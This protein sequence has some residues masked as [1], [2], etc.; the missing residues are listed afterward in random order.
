[1]GSLVDEPLD[2]QV[3]AWL[4]GRE[5][6]IADPWPLYSRMRRETAIFEIGDLMLV[7]RYADVLQLISDPR[8]SN[9]KFDNLLVKSQ[10]DQLSG[11]D[12]VL[13]EE[14]ADFHSNFLSAT[15]PP[16]HARRRRLQMH[17]FY[18]R[19]LSRVTGYVEATVDRLLDAATAK[20]DFDFVADFAY[21]LPML[22]I[23][24]MLGVPEE[25]MGIVLKGSQDHG[26]VLGHGFHKVPEVAEGLW[27]FKN[28]VEDTIE[29]RRREPKDDLLGALI[30]AHYLDGQ[31]SPIELTTSFFNL[32]FS[33]H[34][35]TT[36][37]LANGM[38]ALLQNPGQWARLVD[39]ENTIDATVEELL[40]FVSPVQSIMRTVPETFEFQD[41]VIR[42][43]VLIRLL[44]GS[45]NHDPDFFQDPDE[46]NVGRPND[47]VAHVVFGKGVHYCMGN[48][49][50]RLEMRAAFS[51]IA[52]RTPRPQLASDEI[53]W[54]SS[55]L[56]RR[57]AAL[58]MR[59]ES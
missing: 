6:L 30:N 1:M 3:V 50:S 13:A 36:T 25:D 4:G 24:H 26:V 10:I 27:A 40:R 28:Y 58:P 21:P 37:A 45:A 14:W 5:D 49:L 46:L 34:E 20:G 56:L 39:D 18:P 32:L 57:V 16:D 54:N 38:L 19:Q 12:R 51:R 31:L 42:R 35:T 48:N 52:R 55:P 23:A 8:L 41:H 15:D 33:G 17:G 53:R 2:D 29:R 43:G 7:P 11:S 44:L 9:R 59:L 22:V 47:E